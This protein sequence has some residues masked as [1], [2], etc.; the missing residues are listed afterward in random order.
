MPPRVKLD[1]VKHL[2]TAEQAAGNGV[3]R[4]ASLKLPERVSM[5]IRPSGSLIFEGVVLGRPVP[6]KAPKVDRKGRTIPTADYKRFTAWKE[7]VRAQVYCDAAG[8]AVYA[9]EVA[10]LATFYLR[11]KPGRPPDTTN[12]FKAF[13]DGLQGVVFLND[14]QVVQTTV[15]RVIDPA[16]VERVEFRVEAF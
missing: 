5:V 16:E 6:W 11:A 8:M 10:V 14:S 13:E 9:G 2:L 1:D 12:L 4:V 7:G 3:V 15:S